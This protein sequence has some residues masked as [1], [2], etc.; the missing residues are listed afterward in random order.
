MYNSCHTTFE[1]C[2]RMHLRLDPDMALSRLDVYTA[3]HCIIR[4]LLLFRKWE[5][6]S[7]AIIG[8]TMWWECVELSPHHFQAAQAHALVS[9]PEMALS[10][11]DVSTP[12]AA[13][14]VI[15]PI[16]LF[17]K[18][19][20]VSRAIHMHN[21]TEAHP[22]PSVALGAPFSSRRPPAALR[23]I[24]GAARLRTVP[25]GEG[26]RSWRE[27]DRSFE[28]N[29]WRRMCLRAAVHSL[30]PRVAPLAPTSP[31]EGRRQPSARSTAPP[32]FARCHAARADAL[33]GSS[34]GA[35]RATDGA[36]CA[37]VQLCMR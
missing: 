36:G 28:G 26:G 15:R 21:C 24:D 37:S 2:K 7:R 30:T 16:L 3:A 14:C 17:R 8:V 29:R 25:C 34:T 11:L 12:T 33:G 31:R 27:F 6:V 1:P 13:H 20:D 9:R 18:W 5:D 19:E 22:A 23:S 35:S 10:R 32:A 4:P